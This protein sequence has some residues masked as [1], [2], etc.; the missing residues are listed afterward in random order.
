MSMVQELISAVTT[1]ERQIDDQISKLN[2]YVSEIDSVTERVEANLSG[3]QMD[4][5]S[6]ML[7]QLAETKKQVS[8]TIER[9][10]IAKEK[11]IQVR[12]V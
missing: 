12:L 5:G 11:L 1:A 3:S 8:Q 10:Q 4:Y 6:Q 2:S 7:Q 9:L